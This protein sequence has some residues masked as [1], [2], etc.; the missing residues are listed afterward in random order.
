MNNV[1]N[2]GQ[3]HVH[4]S[5]LL[6]GRARK[7]NFILI[8]YYH[9]KVFNIDIAFVVTIHKLKILILSKFISNDYTILDITF[10]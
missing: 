10:E 8:S 1:G 7:T 4:Q 5:L 9:N 3:D 6:Y 2:C